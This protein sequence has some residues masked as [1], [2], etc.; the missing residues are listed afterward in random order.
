VLTSPGEPSIDV[1]WLPGYGADWKPTRMPKPDL[2]YTLT[3]EGGHGLGGSYP[4]SFGPASTPGLPSFTSQLQ[5]ERGEDEI[6]QCC[7]TTWGSSTA[8][9]TT[10]KQGSLRL[11]AKLETGA[12]PSELTQ[13]LF[14]MWPEDPAAAAFSAQR[15]STW[16]KFQPTLTWTTSDDGACFVFEVT[17]I[18]TGETHSYSKLERCAKRGAFGEIGKRTPVPVADDSLSHTVC[19]VP[20]LGFEERWCDIN[21]AQCEGARTEVGCENFGHMCNGE[22]KPPLPWAVDEPVLP[23]AA[24][25]DSQPSAAGAVGSMRPSRPA[26]ASPAGRD[27]GCSLRP[28]RATAGFGWAQL[29]ALAFFLGRRRAFRRLLP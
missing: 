25:S 6:K 17:D 15:A 28:A 3:L 7:S 23:A 8:C 18:A 16:P 1:S 26:S 4:V 2:P 24:G 14:G 10:E 27:S 12:T 20:P 21:R 29:V 11:M 9:F 13:F 19:Q 22:R 5:V